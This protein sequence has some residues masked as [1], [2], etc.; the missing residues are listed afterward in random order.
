MFVLGFFFFGTTVLIPV[1]SQKLL[2]YTAE[3][4]GLVISP[5]GFGIMPL[6]PIVGFLGKG[7]R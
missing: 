3:Q 4:S 1:L 2:G 5:G 6:M 7:Q